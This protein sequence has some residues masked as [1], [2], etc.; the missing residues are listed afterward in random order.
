MSASTKDVTNTLHYLATGLVEWE[1]T[2]PDKRIQIPQPLRLGMSRMYATATLSGKPVPATLPELFEWAAKPIKSWEPAK[3]LSIIPDNVTLIENGLVSDFARDWALSGKDSIHQIQELILAKLKEYCERNQ[4]DESYRKARELIGT[5]P[6]LTLTQLRKKLDTKELAKVRDFFKLD[7]EGFY[8]PVANLCG[9]T[10]CRLCPRCKYIQRLWEGEYICR[11]KSCELIVRQKRLK[12]IRVIPAEEINEWVAVTP[13]VH[14]YGTIPGIWELYLRDKLV[15]LGALVT[16]YPQT[17]R[18][19]LL[20]EFPN[21]QKW[22]ID[23]KDWSY[24]SEER[25]SKVKCQ[26]DVDATFVVFPDENDL[27]I[28]AIRKRKKFQP[29]A[30]KGLHLRSIGEI[31]KAAKEIV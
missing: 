20:V 23:V 14:R 21:S 18:Y 15:E 30:L 10:E 17:D 6:V 28:P 8:R 7:D 27:N 2:P 31:I 13:G 22:A 1:D 25:L 24:V 11:K 4:L 16:L 19:D 12:N 26:P 3:G 9:G 5:H 29:Q